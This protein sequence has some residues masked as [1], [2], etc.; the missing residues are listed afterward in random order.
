MAHDRTRLAVMAVLLL[1]LVLTLIFSVRGKEQ[2]SP[3]PTFDVSD[4]QTIAVRT[5]AQGLTSTAGAL[6]TSTPTDTPEPTSATATEPTDSVSPTPS[7]YR[8]K[9]VHDVTIPDN[10]PMTPAQVFTKTWQ[11]ENNG[12]CAWRQGFKLVLIGG[13]AMGGS[14]V[15]IIY[16]PWGQRSG[17]HFNPA[18]TLTF[19]RLGKVERWDAIYYILAQFAGGIAG[20]YIAMLVLRE[21]VAHPAVQFVATLPG[22]SGEAAAFF[23]EVAIT[24]L[25]MSVVLR[26]SNSLRLTRWTGL[27]AGVLVWLYISFEAPFSGMSMNPARTF[28]SAFFARTWTALWIYFTAPPLGMLLA[29][30][31]YLR[32]KGLHSVLCAKLHH[33]NSKRCIFRCNFG[34]LGQT[35]GEDTPS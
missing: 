27:F 25:L 29:A 16:S 18:V 6:P 1:A 2:A 20:V 11:V 26:V 32:R 14:A 28:G 34:S 31:L 13:L 35:T 23:A 4:V 10:T 5:F 22:M 30:E 8:M 17:A 9:F 33:C 7:C 15:A 19:F 21:R 24:F 3:P 12:I